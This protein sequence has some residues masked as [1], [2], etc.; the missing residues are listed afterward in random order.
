MMGFLDKVK[1]IFGSKEDVESQNSA[2]NEII[3]EPTFTESIEKDNENF[4]DNEEI[5]S[6]DSVET[7]ANEEV[8]DKPIPNDKI[9]NFKYLDDLIHSGVKEI[10][11][12]SDIVL[13]KKEES[14]Y[15]E[16]IKLDVD[17]LIIDGNGHAI[18]A[19][20]L[21]R[22]FHCTGKNII[23]KNITLIGGYHDN[24]GAIENN[25]ELT[26]ISS[27][28][29]EN[30][31]KWGGSI[32]NK[33]KLTIT[34]STLVENTS[35]KEGG[36]IDNNRGELAII[37]SILAGNTSQYGGA[38]YNRGTLTID[39]ST[40]AQ[41]TSRWGGAIQNSLVSKH[42]DPRFGKKPSKYRGAGIRK[43]TKITLTI[44]DSTLN[45]NSSRWG[46]AILNTEGDLK[47]FNC[48][49]SNNKSSKNII[50]NL[51]SLQFYNTDFTG[52]HAPSVITIEDLSKAGIFNGRFKDNDITK[53]VI[54]NNGQ[55]CTIE[56]GIFENNNSDIIIN[57]CDLTL[58]YPKI[59]DEIKNILNEGY[60]LLKNESE[61]LL[62]YI[63]G[64]GTVDVDT[65]IIPKSKT[66]DF[67]YLERKIQQCGMNE[68]ILDEDIHL[69]KYE[70]DF[71]EGGIEL[72]ID[73]LIINGNGHI[74]DGAGQ[75]RIFLITAK[76]ITLK[77]IILKN[78]HAYKNYDNQFNNSGGAIKINK[79][80][81]LILKNCKF[82]NNTSEENGGAICNMGT[83]TIMGSTLMDNASKEESGGA[84]YNGGMLT[85]MGSTLTENTAQSFG[86][87]G[88][89]HNARS[90]MLTINDSKLMGNTAQRGGGAINNNGGEST[91]RGS[92]LTGNTAN[93][94]GAI[95]NNGGD[96]TICGS[97]LNENSA[98]GSGGAINNLKGGTLT[99]FDS[100]L[101]ENS[102]YGDGGALHNVRRGKLTI[103]DSKLMGNTAQGSGG[104]L[105]NAYSGML[106]IRDSTIEENAAQ[107]YGGAIYNKGRI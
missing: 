45:E 83:L 103:N 66:Y 95:K 2:N 72:D 31:S 33:G 34:D 14:E 68:I 71:Y 10:V 39:D 92:T 26:I 79:N 86:S 56:K 21:T 20:G 58:I 37:D 36:A 1:K 49:F 30:T 59:K 38:I 11:L 47:V 41:N 32:Y 4:N 63:Y 107:K 99:V 80:A 104:A 6:N 102:T 84:I 9:K 73:N 8:T 53:S 87:G 43:A 52:N 65:M 61:D 81:Q 7:P 18:D 40:L 3:D 27:T 12:D 44:R 57:K 100:T 29:A 17:D 74:I 88:A 15:L 22:I 93:D 19:Q 51:D 42:E 50:Y 96:L 48:V 55:S 90:G 16:G 5:K 64:N 35:Q 25:S 46:G 13:D 97:S 62:D 85:I 98:Q 105:Y 24:G 54:F 91:I 76:N 75:S 28:L 70:T 89:I 106:T 77:N 67:G 23:I 60:I 69:E 101:K 94:G 82:I 78:G